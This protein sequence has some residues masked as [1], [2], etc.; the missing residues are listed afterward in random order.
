MSEELNVHRAS[1]L[2][3]AKRRTR[4]P[5]LF[6]RP[7]NN[8]ASPYGLAMISYAFF[9]FACLIPPSIYTDYMME[10]DLMFLDPATIL[11]Y[12]LC[13][14]SFMAGVWVM[15]W[16]FPS[17]FVEPKFRTRI[18]PTLFLMAPLMVGIL[19]TTG[20][21]FL[22]LIYHPEIVFLLLTAQGQQLKETVAFDV[23]TSVNLAP[24][25]LTAIVWWAYWRS[26]DLRLQGWKTRWLKPALV[27]AVLLLIVTSTLILSRDILVM[28]LCGLA[29]LYVIRRSTD[30]P[31]SFRFVLRTG[32]PIAISFAVLFF[33][34]AFLRGSDSL[35]EQIHELFG[36]TV[37]S[38]NRLAAIVNGELRFP[39]AGRGLYVSAF[40]AFNHTFNRIFL[41]NNYMNWPD[42]LGIWGSE[43]EAV[44]RAGLDG[45][46]VWPGAFGLIFSDF[47]WFSVP[48]LFGYGI[49]YGLVWNSIKLGKTLGVVLYPCLGFCVLFWIGSNA[50]L[51]SQRAVLLVAAMAIVAYELIFVRKL[52]V[53]SRD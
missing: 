39:F 19:A 48:F 7:V 4:P 43:F 33:G 16:L 11:F 13:V 37:A 34:F 30:T 24:L 15:G 8:V 25:A 44:T 32:A 31:F 36:Y 51:D 29:I 14:A 49:V 47:G 23:A 21:L 38:Y 17:R 9:L 10:R 2:E 35:A 50:L 18:S 1:H 52:A 53:R 45:H 27:I 42:P 26:F 5:R 6:N 46:L 41:L 20:T 28:P 40:V 22:L 12:T 3:A